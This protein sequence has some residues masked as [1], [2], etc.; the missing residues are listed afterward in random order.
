MEEELNLAKE[1]V[2]DY[3]D[4]SSKNSERLPYGIRESALPY[5]KDIIQESMERVYL[6]CGVS[7]RENKNSD[8]KNY[9]DLLGVGYTF[10]GHFLLE[11]EIE[12]QSKPAPDDMESFAMY[13]EKLLKK[14]KY[15]LDRLEQMK[16]K[17][18]G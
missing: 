8:I 18:N 2:Q 12:F 14:E 9:L 13:A 15:Y 17:I 5:P 11:N 1:I 6:A 16:E 3:L 10:L 7:Y 4:F